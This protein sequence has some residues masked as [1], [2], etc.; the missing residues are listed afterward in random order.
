MSL[1][2][3]ESWSS[4]DF[5]F[6]L[7]N[8]K[9]NPFFHFLWVFFNNFCFQRREFPMIFFLEFW[10]N[11]GKKLKISPSK[12]TAFYFESD[13]QTVRI[14]SIIFRFSLCWN[15]ICWSKQ[16]LAFEFLKSSS[17]KEVFEWNF[18]HQYFLECS[19]SSS[20]ITSFSTF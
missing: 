13:L 5:I 8:Q 1:I 14:L 2:W 4:L 17:N 16:K 6:L 20:R 18:F 11:P 19:R 12:L 7:K 15:F 3:S 9:K 10:K